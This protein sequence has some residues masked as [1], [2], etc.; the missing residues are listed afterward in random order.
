[1]VDPSGSVIYEAFRRVTDG[2]WVVRAYTHVSEGN[3]RKTAVMGP[4][5]ILDDCTRSPYSEIASAGTH[6]IVELLSVL[7]ELGG[8]ATHDVA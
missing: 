6:P 3:A 4:D 7:S 5:S 1:M 2:R 8:L